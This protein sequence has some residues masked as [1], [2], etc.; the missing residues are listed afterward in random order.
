MIHQ[1]GRKKL[2]IKAPHK[3]ALLRNQAIHMINYGHL[4]STKAR[5]KETQRFVERIVTIAREGNTFNARRRVHA[6]LPY[7]ASAVV[8]LFK[9]IA[10]Q[11]V[12]RPG[13]YTRLIPLGKRMSD[14]A[15]VA[16]LEWVK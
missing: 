7:D 8:K 13:G 1:N 14:T 15:T 11:Y 6:L 9:D 5:A 4:V 16:R 3:R 10:P 2:N 12:T